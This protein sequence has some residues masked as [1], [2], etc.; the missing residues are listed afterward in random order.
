MKEITKQ[1]NQI[2]DITS[3]YMRSI[4]ENKFRNFLC[5]IFKKRYK[6]PK[7]EDGKNILKDVSDYN[8]DKR[9]K[10]IVRLSFSNIFDIRL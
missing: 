8:S 1:R 7:E 2:K 3:E 10:G 9:L 5:R 4:S 6:A